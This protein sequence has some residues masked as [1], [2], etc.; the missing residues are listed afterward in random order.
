MNDP[1][2]VAAISVAGLLAGVVLTMVGQRYIFG[3]S[4]ERRA[5]GYEILTAN[6]IIPSL[7]RPNPAVRLTVK[8]SV[9]DTGWDD[10][11]D[12]D[13]VD[14]DEVYG[15]R[16]RIRNA[17]NRHLVNP[18]PVTFRFPPGTKAIMADLEC[19]PE[20]GGRAVGV[21]IDNSQSKV[22][23]TF[24]FLNMR[25]EAIVSIQTLYNRDLSCKIIAA[26]PGLDSFDMG[27]RRA[28][29]GWTVFVALF[30]LAV[31]SGGTLLGLAE[32]GAV[33]ESTA[34]AMRTV[35]VPLLGGGS[36]VFLSIVFPTIMGRVTG[37]TK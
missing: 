23:V 9:L 30:V 8:Q 7:A 34:E 11:D 15:F 32:S 6:V 27:R 31:A 19:S 26:G 36:M 18:Q 10:P 14:V 3:L 25:D 20:F 28:I 1:W 2:V 24:P 29:L 22:T 33:D 37:R 35:A 16:V 17:G 21:D 12:T 13:F 5:V 4:R